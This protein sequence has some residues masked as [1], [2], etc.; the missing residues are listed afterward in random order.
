VNDIEAEFNGNKTKLRWSVSID[1]KKIQSETYKILAILDRP[2]QVGSDAPLIVSPQVAASRRIKT[3][4]PL[5]P[6]RRV[7]GALADIPHQVA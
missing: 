1:G 3:G 2:T 6:R 5:R 4:Q 7:R